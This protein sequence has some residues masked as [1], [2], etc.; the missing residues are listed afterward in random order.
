MR[1]NSKSTVSLELRPLAL[2]SQL[3]SFTPPGLSATSFEYYNGSSNRYELTK[4]TTSYGG[5]LEYTYANH[6]FYFGAIY[7][8]SRVVEQKK[9]TFSA[10]EQAKVW[11]FTYPSYQGISSGTAHVQGPEYN[12]DVTHYAYDAASPWKIGLISGLSFG[13]SSF[14]E[15]YDWTFQQLSNQLWT[16]LGVNMGTAKG[17]LLSSVIETRPGDATSKREYLFERTET[18]RFG[19]PTKISFYVNG[20]AQ[21]K[22]YIEYNY[23]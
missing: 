20:S 13:D 18:M 11:T 21:P 17:P 3:A 16:V 14:S 1:L 5:F 2:R 4:V 22:K 15:T 23:V 19:L 8:D 10:G 7:L 9:I 12:T 6:D